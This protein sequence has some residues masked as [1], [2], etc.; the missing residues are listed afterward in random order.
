MVD[1]SIVIGATV[2][3]AGVGAIAAGLASGGAER[4]GSS[5]AAYL[6]SLEGSEHGDLAEEMDDFSRKL[7]QP[8]LDRILSPAVAKLVATVSS[9]TPSDHRVRVRTKLAQAGLDLRRRPEEIIAAQV[10]GAVIG[11]LLGIAVIVSGSFSPGLG[12]LATALLVA[13]G[14][15]APMAWLSRKV[16]ERMQA[17]RADLPDTLD[18]LAISVEAGVGLEG[19]MAVVTE[20]FD[21]PLADEIGRTLQEMGLGLTRR[22]ALSNLKQRS[23][24]PELS[25]FV[26]ALIQAD[27]LGMPL[28]RVLKVQAGEM[29]TKRRQWARE[30]AAKLPVK[31]LFPL[32]LCIFPAVMVVVIGPAISQLKGAF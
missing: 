9:V 18:L 13:L 10:A 30:R 8:F 29:R 27:A 31:I 6:H 28:G 11:L 3:V 24:V 5:A 22:D 19:A 23:Q 15:F 16:D 25:S 20:R 26:Q 4:R 21:S 17:I 2:A 1:G 12:I 32:V 14:G 7:S